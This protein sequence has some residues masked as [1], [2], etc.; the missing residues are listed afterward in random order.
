MIDHEEN[1]VNSESIHTDQD[2]ELNSHWK[3]LKKSLNNNEILSQAFLFLLAGS[4]T[5]ATTMTFLAYLLA[6]NPE[7]QSKL[8]KEIEK[9]FNEHV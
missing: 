4:E 1:S 2:K 3:T 5:T 7:I 6:K 9:S 8:Y